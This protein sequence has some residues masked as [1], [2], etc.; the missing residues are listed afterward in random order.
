M[1]TLFLFLALIFSDPASAQFY[2]YL[3]T[4]QVSVGTVA[5]QVVA[6]RARNA[7]TVNVPLSGATVYCSSSSSVTTSTGF[8]ITAGASYTFQPYNGP[9]W[10]IVASSTQTVYAGES[11]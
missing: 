10:C 7:V 9:V 3:N 6:A 1:R 8:P 5:T 2:Q 11:Y 4:P